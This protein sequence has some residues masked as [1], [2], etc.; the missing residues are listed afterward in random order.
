MQ[1]DPSAMAFYAGGANHLINS[2]AQSMDKEKCK[3]AWYADDSSATGKL[4]EVKKWWDVLNDHG[5]KY[6]YFSKA[7]KSVLIQ[8]DKT[9]LQEARLLFAGSKITITCEGERHLGALIGQEKLKWDYVNSKVMKWIKD[10][11]DLAIIVTDEQQAALSA[12][13]KSVCNRWTFVQRTISDI[14]KLFIPLEES[15]R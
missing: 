10:I 1:R 3:Q 8:K 2:L 14:K 9:L 13:T 4:A 15:I 7:S 11:E 12:Y 6:G 5:P